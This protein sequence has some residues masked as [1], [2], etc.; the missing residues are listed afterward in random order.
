MR[1]LQD[2]KKVCDFR[3]VFFTKEVVNKV[4]EVVRVLETS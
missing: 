1:M 4:V 3:E 2:V